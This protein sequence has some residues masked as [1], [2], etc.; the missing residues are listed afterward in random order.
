MRAL[1][2]PVILLIPGSAAIW[3]A[4]MIGEARK[5]DLESGPFW[6]D[7]TLLSMLGLA[8]VSA[9]LVWLIV[10]LVALARA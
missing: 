8:L 5:G 9:G 4:R 1:L 3:L 7:V 6:A 2:P 10:R